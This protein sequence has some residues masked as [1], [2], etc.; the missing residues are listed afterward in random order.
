MT[1]RL[2]RHN[3]SRLSCNGVCNQHH[4][5]RPPARLSRCLGLPAQGASAIRA[6]DVDEHR[7]RR[8]SEVF[9]AHRRG[10]RRLRFLDDVQVQEVWLLGKRSSVHG[11][12]RGCVSDDWVNV[13]WTPDTLTCSPTTLPGDVLVSKQPM[14]S[15]EGLRYRGWG[16]VWPVGTIVTVI[17][18]WHVDNQLRVL[19][20]HG[21][22]VLLF[23]HDAR[24]EA[25]FRSWCSVIRT[26]V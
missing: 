17:N 9:Q 23:S 14:R 11:S 15:W 3:T 20:I 18:T 21:E 2:T 22:K 16:D 24:T 10:T 26:W 5:A 1:R 13:F 8:L 6:R 19:V 4:F 7:T 12:R 25:V